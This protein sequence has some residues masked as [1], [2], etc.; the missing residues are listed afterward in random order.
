MK[1]PYHYELDECEKSVAALMSALEY[2]YVDVSVTVEGRDIVVA[3]ADTKAMVAFLFALETKRR[4][5][6]KEHLKEIDPA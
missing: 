6:I 5:A 2:R 4:D 3:P 1:T